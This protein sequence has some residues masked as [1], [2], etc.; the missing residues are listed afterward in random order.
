M[1][2]GPGRLLDIVTVDLPRPR[3]HEERTSDDYYNYVRVV[4]SVLDNASQAGREK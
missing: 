4:R 2:S 3:S 1:T